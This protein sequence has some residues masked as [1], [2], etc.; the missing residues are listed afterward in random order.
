MTRTRLYVNN[1]NIDFYSNINTMRL[2]LLD[3]T[4]VTIYFNANIDTNG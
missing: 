2:Y 1:K 3:K 4:T